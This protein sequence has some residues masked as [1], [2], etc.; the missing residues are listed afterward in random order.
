M[1]LSLRCHRLLPLLAMF[2]CLTFLTPSLRAQSEAPKF[3]DLAAQYE[4][5]KQ[6]SLDFTEVG[7]EMRGNVM[8]IDLLYKGSSEVRVPAY[9][10]IPKGDGPFAAILW[11]HW[12]MPGSP[13]RNRDQFLNEAV[14][15]ARAG[16]VS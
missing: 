8:V 11:G 16:A 10:V 9:L 2:L 13:L 6:T 4:F 1:P 12:L 3:E 15:L 14:V 7:V 5:N